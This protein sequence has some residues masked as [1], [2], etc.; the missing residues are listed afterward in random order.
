MELP[1][2]WAEVLDE[3]TG[4][5]YFW[6]CDTDETTW[7]PPSMS[8][9]A[10][11][12]S[13]KT[14][15]AAVATKKKQARKPREVIA[16]ES[17]KEE[18]YV[19]KV[20][21]KSD[22]SREVIRTALKRSFIFESLGPEDQAEMIDSMTKVEASPGD[23]IIVQ[24]DS[25]DNFYVIESGSFDILIDGVG[26]VAERG[27]GDSFGEKALLYNCPRAATVTAASAAKLWALDR[28]TF[29]H[30][31]AH[32]SAEKLAA[33]VTAL[34][35]VPL[36]EPLTDLQ[37]N[38]IAEAVKVSEYKDGDVI[39][40]KGDQGDEF[41]MV[42]SG[43]VVCKDIRS[44]G[45]AVP[46]LALGPGDFFGE[47]AL[48]LS[49]PRAANVVATGNVSCLVLG[50]S[51][52]NTLLGPLH[53]IIDEQLG[54][55]V[56]SGVPVLRPLRQSERKR[57]VAAFRKVKFRDGDNLAQAGRPLSAFYV[58]KEGIC[59]CRTP[60]KPAS[61]LQAGDFVGDVALLEASATAEADV[62][63]SGEVQC[64]TITK[65]EFEG[66]FGPLRD[67]LGRAPGGDDDSGAASSGAAGGAGGSSGEGRP[68]TRDVSDPSV[69]GVH[70]HDLEH[71]TT[72]GAGTFGRVKLVKHRPTGAAYA[73]KI[74]QK[75]QVVDFKQT[76]N[77]M[78]ERDVMAMVDHPFV[79]KLVAT[80][81]DKDCLYMLLELVSGGELF[82]LL[83]NQETGY[84]SSDAAKFYAAC[85]ISA[86][87]ALHERNILY[88]D[89]KPE[90][91]LIDA[92]GY[93]KVVDMGF[94]KVVPE[95]TFTLCGTPEYLAPELVLGKGHHKG[96]D[97]W[98]AG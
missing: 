77:V 93:I 62:V 90:N 85:V 4:D 12:G 22:A 88:R 32:T 81:K 83:A 96:V 59:Q 19:K 42:K 46:D 16:A 23:R 6:N 51:D 36:L 97:Y 74:L 69:T 18:E 34:R 40:K 37:L 55:R 3:E 73:L 87:E 82:T 13:D 43:R 26:K 80:F 47:R 70:F 63:A 11:A 61:L 95:R 98:A 5:V 10:A 33:I 44:G 14:G 48:L 67:L 8:D 29:R 41:F 71:M 39:I 64:F 58:I 75:A 20:V 28:V 57:V 54:M 45:T 21:P 92:Q 9:G 66:L 76:T 68:G 2:G 31:I 72:L 65:D 60:G 25:G 27:P 53:D 35:A 91:M 49:E 1:P 78:N 38:R 30:M 84:V 94:A 79:L 50:R 86:L 89:L 7:D 56:L 17:Y 24:G 52:F 15:S